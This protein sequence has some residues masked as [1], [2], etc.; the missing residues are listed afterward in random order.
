L[1]IVSIVALENFKLERTDE[2]RREL[3]WRLRRAA[4]SHRSWP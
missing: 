4:R 3:P 1:S 2:G